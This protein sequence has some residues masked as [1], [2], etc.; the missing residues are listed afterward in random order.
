M[1]FMGVRD[2]KV[3]V[4]LSLNGRVHHTFTGLKAIP[5]LLSLD[6][7]LKCKNNIHDGTLFLCVLF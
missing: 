5:H 7:L 3:G 4:F 2:R 6:G 1:D